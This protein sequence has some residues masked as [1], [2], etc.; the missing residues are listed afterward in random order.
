MPDRPKTIKYNGQEYRLVEGV[1]IPTEKYIEQLP[2]EIPSDVGPYVD[3][4]T[5]KYKKNEKYRNEYDWMA[6]VAGQMYDAVKKQSGGGLPAQIQSLI[7]QRNEIAKL[8]D[9]QIADQ[10]NSDPAKAIKTLI[11]AFD[12]FFNEYDTVMQ[13]VSK[14][15]KLGLGGLVNKI[16]KPSNAKLAKKLKHWSDFFGERAKAVK[17]YQEHQ[18]R[19][20][21][22]REEP[23]PL[24]EPAP[25]AEATQPAPGPA[26]TA[27][28]SE[29][30][31]APSPAPSPAPAAKEEA[32]APSPAP[33]EEVPAAQEAPVESPSS[34]P[35]G[36]NP[37]VLKKLINKKR[38]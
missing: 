4:L 16:L 1:G 23:T 20:K 8:M 32:P 18:Q 19:R 22:P 10:A 11:A 27:P 13:Q 14:P 35:F 7:D 37:E 31:P 12:H 33:S 15:G 17:N 9:G 29:E 38:G 5:K 30:A 6:K 3:A 25:A 24:E 28:S 36:F 21:G 34:A 26:P 2:A